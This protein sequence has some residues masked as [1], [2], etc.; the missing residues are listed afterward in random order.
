MTALISQTIRMTRLERLL[1]DKGITLWWAEE[2]D[3][4]PHWVGVADVACSR[5]YNA[6]AVPRRRRDGYHFAEVLHEVAH[7]ELWRW[8]GKSPTKQSD[9]EVCRLA[10]DIAQEYG[11]SADT[12]SH[13][14]RELTEQSKAT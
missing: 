11:F 1:E 14:E 2:R 10:L 3:R 6:V 7:L 12:I 8:T 4:R 13:L 9:A 5:Q